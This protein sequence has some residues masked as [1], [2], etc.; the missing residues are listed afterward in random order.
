MEV[1]FNDDAEARRRF[2]S[3]LPENWVL[4]SSQ[5]HSGRLYYF[6]S[7][8][9]ESRWEH[10]LIPHM[11]PPV[12]FNL[13]ITRHVTIIVGF[14]ITG[15]RGG[16]R[17]FFR[18]GCTRLLLY[19]NTNKPHSFFFCRIPV[20]LEKRRSSQGEGVAHP[21]HPPPRSAP[22]IIVVERRATRDF[23]FDKII[24]RWSIVRKLNEM[25]KANRTLLVRVHLP[26]QPPWKS[27]KERL[28]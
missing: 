14:F 27:K 23:Y 13:V 25:Y 5:T 24:F 9:G 2:E 16:S 8:T 17:I 1:E 22:G 7:V 4:C 28:H 15:Y 18:R 10:P 26:T 12:S 19:F 6:N 11:D 21:L 3:S 20:V